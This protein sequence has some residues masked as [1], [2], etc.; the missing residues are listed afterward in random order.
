MRKSFLAAAVLV[1]VLAMFQS[2][3]LGHSH[4]SDEKSAGKSAPNLETLLKA[5]L[6]G[7]DGTE[8]IVSRVTIPP[9]TSLPKVT[10]CVDDIRPEDYSPRSC[11]NAPKLEYPS[12]IIR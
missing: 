6:E 3:I 10:L 1:G 7:V 4:S 5:A 12:S 2:P 8:V 11:V 9:N